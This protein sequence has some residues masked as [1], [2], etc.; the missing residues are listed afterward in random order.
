MGATRAGGGQRLLGALSLAAG[1]LANPASCGV[2]FALERPLD[3]SPTLA[4]IVALQVA[5]VLLGTW[6]LLRESAAPGPTLLWRVFGGAVLLL[7]GAGLV[8]TLRWVATTSPAAALRSAAGSGENRAAPDIVLVVLD[9]TRRDR[10]SLHGYERPTTPGL[11]Q[12]AGESTV[13]ERAY[14]T[15]SWTAPAHASL[16]TG[17][18]PASH[19]VTQKA[20]SLPSGYATLAE[21]L[22]ERGYHTAAA[23]GNP[24][25][26]AGLGFDQGFDE[27]VETWRGP[28]QDQAPHPAVRVLERLLDRQRGPYFA[29]FN[30]IEPHS[31]YTSTGPYAEE[32]VRDPSIELTANR[33][34]QHYTGA[35]AHGEA[36]LAHLGDL[37]DAQLRHADE[38]VSE[39]VELLRTRGRL[40]RTV[41]V[42]TADHGENLGDHGHLDHVFSLYETTVRIPLLVRYPAEFDPGQRVTAPVQLPDLFTTLAR[43]GG[44]PGAR[45][46]GLDLARD[47][48]PADRAVLLSYDFPLQAL[49]AI[50]AAA[51]HPALDVQRRRLWALIEGE[52]KLVAGSDGLLEL[53]DLGVDPDERR[54]LSQTNPERT[55]ALRARLLSVLAQRAG[56]ERVDTVGPDE[57][58]DEEML[59]ALRALGYVE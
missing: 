47:E 17:L 29:F 51:E 40:D 38:L 8:G 48:L 18:W 21:L 45:R 20:W 22:R 35:A 15:S 41:L 26:G 2:I 52:W 55:L 39:L 12:L 32:F 46:Q 57:V 1:L 34:R 36:E 43:L 9:T 19:G 16:F 6:L 28:R 10:T 33:W 30:F 25:L 42:V 49:A 27:Y 58:F 53:Y 23:V 24:M 5:L 56:P 11:E 31:P 13:F 4:A 59:R 14:S 37:Y 50:G 7:I 54:D 44:V 3:H